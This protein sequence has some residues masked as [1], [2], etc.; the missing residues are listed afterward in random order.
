[1]SA[2]LLI[3]AALGAPATARAPQ[4]DLGQEAAEVLRARCFPC[5]SPDSGKRKAVRAWSNALDVAATIEEG[6]LEPGDPEG[7]ELW[8]LVVEGDMPPDD[9]ESGPL[10]EDERALLFRWI[11]S[12]AP[13]SP[14]PP[15]AETGEESAGTQ[16][17]P[18]GGA[19]GE[20]GADPAQETEDAPAERASGGAFAWTDLGVLHPLLVHF[21]IAL[22]LAAVLSEILVG[23]GARRLRATSRFCAF[24]G[25][26]GGVAA[27]ASGWL[28]AETERAQEVI[29]THR[30]LG[31]A[32]GA[33]A[34]LLV[35][36]LES[37]SRGRGSRFLHVLFLLATAVL[38]TLTGHWGAM[39]SYGEGYLDELLGHVSGWVR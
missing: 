37:Q 12:G 14:A 11:E 31:V 15:A 9:A 21:P 10:S 20:P 19:D 3:L 25:L 13:A 35:L 1:M 33:C 23:L 24:L 5:H 4:A 17:T 26:L 36:S 6:L 29:E 28:L 27:G 2:V 34:V 18:G 32:T 38:V 7:S 22:L 16:D 39:T 30:W 8:L